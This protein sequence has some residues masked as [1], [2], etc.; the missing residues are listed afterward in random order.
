MSTHRER[1]TRVARAA[2]DINNRR[3]HFF[4]L[5]RARYFALSVS[6]GPAL[7]LRTFPRL[8]PFPSPPPRSLNA[9]PARPSRRSAPN[10]SARSRACRRRRRARPRTAAP[11]ARNLMTRNRHRLFRR[12]PSNTPSRPH[13]RCRTRSA[14]RRRA[15]QQAARSA[16]DQPRSRPPLFGGART[17]S[18]ARIATRREPSPIAR[19]V[20]W[21]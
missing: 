19:A 16:T 9:S 11:P 5:S 1:R 14:S 10:A 21:R 7:R 15:R 18:G 17:S 20:P 13:S 6:P 2:V 4:F 3:E 8:D 12:H